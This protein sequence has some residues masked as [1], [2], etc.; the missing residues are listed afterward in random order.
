MPTV[1]ITVL[2]TPFR[3]EWLK[4]KSVRT[5]KPKAPNPETDLEFISDSPEQIQNSVQ[6]TGY[7]DKLDQAFKAAIAKA[8]KLTQ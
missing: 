5:D 6:Y 4:E 3:D 1:L 8:K 7:R 2:L